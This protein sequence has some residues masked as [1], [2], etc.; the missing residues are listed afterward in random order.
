MTSPD[1]SPPMR[2]KKGSRCAPSAAFLQLRL[3][4]WFDRDPP[5]IQ[6]MGFRYSWSARRLWRIYHQL[7]RNQTPTA[8][9]LRCKRRQEDWRSRRL[10]DSSREDGLFH[11]CSHSG[12]GALLIYQSAS[13]TAL[14]WLFG[15]EFLGYKTKLGPLILTAF[16]IGPTITNFVRGL[17]D[18]LLPILAEGI[19]RISW[20]SKSSYEYENAP[21]RSVE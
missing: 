5:G 1:F 18:D 7:S 15:I 11:R 9:M 12:R 20:P 10:Q 6:K 2:Q 4:F 8:A 13:A 16:V 19:G 17:L 3:D 14:Q 21:W